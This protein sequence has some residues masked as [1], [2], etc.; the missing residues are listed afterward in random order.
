MSA[1][2]IINLPI[3]EKSYNYA[4]IYSSLLNDEY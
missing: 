1:T 4:K 2:D 3:D